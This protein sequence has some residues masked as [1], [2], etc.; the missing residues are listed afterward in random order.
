M[1]LSIFFVTTLVYTGIYL[2]RHRKAGGHCSA[3]RS[4]APVTT[5]P[6]LEQQPNGYPTAVPA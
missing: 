1:S 2:H 3:S 4:N 6:K 5:E